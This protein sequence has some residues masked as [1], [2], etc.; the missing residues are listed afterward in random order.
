VKK[1]IYRNETINEES[2]EESIA[3]ESGSP[4]RIVF[5]EVEEKTE[6]IASEW[7]HANAS[8]AD[9]LEEVN[10]LRKVKIIPG[11]GYSKSSD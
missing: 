11:H 4:A 1:T 9:E 8:R 10:N 7:E 3:S 6:M 2:F 5:T